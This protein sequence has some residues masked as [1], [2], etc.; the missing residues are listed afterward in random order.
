MRTSKK[1][2]IFILTL[3]CILTFTALSASAAY[4]PTSTITHNGHEYQVYLIET[5]WPDAQ[6]Y[7]KSLGG[8]LVTMETAEESEMIKE[9]VHNE[10]L[11]VGAMSNGYYDDSDNTV[12]NEIRWI[13]N[14]E[15]VDGSYIEPCL[16]EPSLMAKYYSI[17]FSPEYSSNLLIGNFF[18]HNTM[19]GFICEIEPTKYELPEVLRPGGYTST[20]TSD[21][22]TSTTVETLDTTDKANDTMA[23]SSTSTDET[24]EEPNQN[25]SD[26]VKTDDSSTNNQPE[27]TV[28]DDND[29]ITKNLVPETK[30]T[31]V[32]SNTPKTVD[33]SEAYSTQHHDRLPFIVWIGIIIAISIAAVVIIFIKKKTS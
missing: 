30:P 25:N 6:E 17:S 27:D 19:D 2:I 21:E 3:M 32:E 23:K 33:D 4:R 11:W 26:E 20:D 16:G 8:H 14:G 31:A 7:C 5:T 18:E 15:E 22:N 1:T 29:K 28:E 13:T 10:N 12:N 9:L 24:T